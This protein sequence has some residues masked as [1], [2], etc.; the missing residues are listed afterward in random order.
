MPRKSLRR[1]ALDLM[2]AKV[3]KLS[4]MHI[5]REATDEDDSLADDELIIESERLDRLK[6]KV[7]IPS[8][9]I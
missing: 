7:P 8:I 9:F 5:I 1:K 6:K 4:L 2:Q 3:H